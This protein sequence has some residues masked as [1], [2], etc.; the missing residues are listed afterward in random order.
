MTAMTYAVRGIGSALKGVDRVWGALILLFVILA[1]ALPEQA[2]ESIAFTLDAFLWIL[3]FLVISVLLAAWLKAAGVDGLIARA[4][5]R[6]PVRTIVLAAL[7]GALSPFC[8]CGVVPLVAALLAAGMPLPAVM[9]FWIASPIMDPEMF[10]LM[11][12]VVGLPFTLAKTVAAIALGLMAGFATLALE[13]TGLLADPLRAGIG[14]GGCARSAAEPAGLRWT[15][16]HEAP[17]R[18]LF[19]GEARSVSLFLSKCRGRPRPPPG[20]TDALPPGASR[21]SWRG[22]T[23]GPEPAPRRSPPTHRTGGPTTPGSSSRRGRRTRAHSGR[24][25][26]GSR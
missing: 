10:V 5:S 20:R 16:W 2:A 13:R 22:S 3:P 26:G 14:C 25:A 21:R 12:V 17:R 24:R 23:P 6:S 7:F 9:A 18:T 1:L 15:F 8:S 19:A 4:V 11:A